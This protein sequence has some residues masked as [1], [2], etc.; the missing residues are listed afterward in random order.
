MDILAF[1]PDTHAGRHTAWLW[2]RTLAIAGGAPP[3]DPGEL[4]AHFA[5]TVLDQV[6]AE[7]LLAV[8]VQLAPAL[9]LVTRLVAE[10]SSGRRYTALLRLPDVWLRYTCLVQDDEPHLLTGVGYL[11]ALDPNSYADRRVQRDGRDVRVRDFGGTGPLLLLWHGAGGDCTDWEALAPHL[12]GFHVVAQDLPGH[13]RSPLDVFTTGDALADADAVVGELDRGPPAVVGHSLGGYLGLR[14]AATRTCSGWVGLDGP[15][16]LAYPW[17]ADAPGLPE[18]ALR[19]GR[20][21]RAIDVA[22]DFAAVQC[23][24][25]LVLCATGPLEERTAPARQELAEY[26]ARQHPEVRLEWV[27]TGHDTVVFHQPRETAA[28]VRDFLDRPDG[29]GSDRAGEG[30]T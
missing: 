22:R 30:V 29:G 4:A 18:A 23:P 5:P 27:Q 9:P 2:S 19:I 21:I 28:I 13:G 17:D 8:L 20:E 7:Q 6:P 3:P 16:G 25:M 26:L 14:Y 10:A 12:A 11:P 1:L 24:A 15:F